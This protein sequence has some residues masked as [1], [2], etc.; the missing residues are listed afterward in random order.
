MSTGDLLN[1]RI[2]NT[3]PILYVQDM[4]RSLKFYVD[5]LG[6]RNAAWGDD[7]FT[8]V[9]RDGGGLYLCKSGQ[10]LPGTWVWI[11]F[12]GDIFALHEQLVAKGVNIKLPPTNFF[13]SYEMR[14]EDPDG[15]VLRLG[16]DPDENEPFAEVQ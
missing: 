16:T 14:I 2:E 15:H 4:G 6:F 3:T 10:G 8:M 9:S 11:G 13:H 5:I 12:D 7:H 1:Y